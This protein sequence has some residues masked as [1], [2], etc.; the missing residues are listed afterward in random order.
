MCRVDGRKGK[1]LCFALL[2]G[3]NTHLESDGTH[4]CHLLQLNGFGLPRFGHLARATQ[5]LTTLHENAHCTVECCIWRCSQ[6]LSWCLGVLRS[7]SEAA[8]SDLGL[9]G[10]L[11]HQACSWQDQSSMSSQQLH[12]QR[13]HIRAILLAHFMLCDDLHST[14]AVTLR[15]TSLLIGTH[16]QRC[17][18]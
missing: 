13:I 12:K 15:A 5:D 10:L 9:L 6:V 3:R 7:W 1:L 2:C 4:A 14:S 11:S 16:T 18:W 17:C 8:T